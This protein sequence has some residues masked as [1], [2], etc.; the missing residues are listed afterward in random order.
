[1]TIELDAFSHSADT[2]HRATQSDG[3]PMLMGNSKRVSLSHVMTRLIDGKST[4]GDARTF[5]IPRQHSSWLIRSELLFHP[6]RQWFTKGPITPLFRDFAWSCIPMH[7][8]FTI[9]GYIF[10]YY[11]IGCAWFLTIMNYFIMGW[12]SES[13]L[14]LPEHAPADKYQSTWTDTICH[15]G[16]SPWFVSSFSSVSPTLPLSFFDTD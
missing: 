13:L 3:H 14:R 1:M 10:S 7:S 15:H 5:S 11:A 12:N 6:F 9:C 16:M 8:K 2:R 4:L